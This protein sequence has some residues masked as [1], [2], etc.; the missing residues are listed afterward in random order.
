MWT[1]LVKC[2]QV[3]RNVIC[4]PQE[5]LVNRRRGHLSSF[6]GR[7]SLQGKCPC[8]RG[9]S[10]GCF[11]N[12][13]SGCVRGLS[14][15]SAQYERGLGAR[16]ECYYGLSWCFPAERQG[17]PA[18]QGSGQDG[19]HWTHGGAPAGKNPSLPAWENKLTPSL[20]G[21]SSYP[22]RTDMSQRKEFI[23][24]ISNILKNYLCQVD[25]S[26]T[27][28]VIKQCSRREEKA[29]HMWLFPPSSLTFK[30]QQARSAAALSVEHF[31]AT[32]V[33]IETGV[34]MRLEKLWNLFL[35]AFL[36][37]FWKMSLRKDL[38]LWDSF[39]C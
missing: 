16:H 32:E 11:G 27:V 7:G 34:G 23:P 24:T 6:A 8:S 21:N 30:V 4:P 1:Q 37:C 14:S 19:T 5:T 33:C 13:G 20:L 12:M 36:W 2:T 9:R 26:G 10:T 22:D 31:W 3:L 38:F 18:F 17:T 29:H 39:V 15:L 25:F 35:S 28:P